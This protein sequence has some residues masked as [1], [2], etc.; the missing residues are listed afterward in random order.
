M[1]KM[2]RNCGEDVL[3]NPTLKRWHDPCDFDQLIGKLQ[4]LLLGFKGEYDLGFKPNEEDSDCCLY[5][6]EESTSVI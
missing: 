3:R 2:V 6:K 4:S 1:A 5:G